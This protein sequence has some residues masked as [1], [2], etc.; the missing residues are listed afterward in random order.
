VPLPRD[1][2]L[3]RLPLAPLFVCCPADAELRRLI[4][5]TYV[6]CVIGLDI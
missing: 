2:L 4:M 3:L 6:M 1:V 5:N